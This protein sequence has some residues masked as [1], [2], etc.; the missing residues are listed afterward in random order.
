MKL[1]KFY[2][3]IGGYGSYTHTIEWKKDGFHYSTFPEDTSG[4]VDIDR[5]GPRINQSGYVDPLEMTISFLDP[6]NEIME[7]KEGRIQLFLKYAKRYCRHWNKEYFDEGIIDGT[8]WEVDI[9]TDEFRLKSSGSN[10]YPGNFES[11]RW[12]L[13]LLTEGKMF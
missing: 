3:Y 13:T 2:F 4:G 12:K 1:K 7:L 10:A 9:W 6:R 8:Q 11:F 5:G